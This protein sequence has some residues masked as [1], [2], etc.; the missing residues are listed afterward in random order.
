MISLDPISAISLSLKVGIWCSILGLPVALCLGWI[1][2]RYRF[3]GKSIVNCIVFCPL[4]IP[5][6]VTGFLLLE[7]FG[8]ASHMGAFFTSIGM[9]FSFSMAGAILASFVVGL[10]F[11]VMAIRSSFESIDP[12]LEEISWSLGVTPKSTFYRVIFPLAFP[13]ILAGMVLVFARALGEFGATVVLAGNIEGKTRTI[14]LA[15]YTLLEMPD[16]GD[17]S[18]ILVGASVGISF[19]SILGYEALS[20]WHKKRLEWLNEG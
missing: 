15:V 9:P 16:G 7:L 1:L 8:R 20:K 2:A 18:R 13:G 14:A 10:P 6:V 19:I 5:P 4:V 12:K 11:Y 17:L 3:F